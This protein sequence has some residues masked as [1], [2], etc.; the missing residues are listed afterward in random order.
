MAEPID[1]NVPVVEDST[2]HA[3][4]TRTGKFGKSADCWLVPGE[5]LYLSQSAIYDLERDAD[6]MAKGHG[7]KTYSQWQ[8]RPT[9]QKGFIAEEDIVGWYHEIETH[10]KMAGVK[11]QYVANREAYEQKCYPGTDAID[12]TKTDDRTSN[13]RNAFDIDR[14]RSSIALSMCQGER[15]L[16]GS[17][18]KHRSYVS[19]RIESPDGRDLV[20]ICMTFDQ[21]ASFLVSSSATPCTIDRFW[22]INEGCVR[23]KEVVHPPESI[24]NRMK[25]RLEDRLADAEARLDAVIATLDEAIDAGKAMSKTKLAEIRKELG[26]FK[27]HNSSNRDF[28]VEQ[29]REE[30]SSIVERAAAT[31]AW[32]QKIEPRDLLAHPGVQ[33]LL[34]TS[35][36]SVKVIS[37]ESRPVSGDQ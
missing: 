12:P 21:F 37:D 19:I 9:Y 13:N 5:G 35:P 28:T 3:T 29:A 25:Q 23:L 24:Q 10:R 15:Y 26:I 34:S 11:D 14:S 31:I 30:V 6:K 32:D 2:L 16:N 20:D 4:P 17:A 1:D 33:Q 18:V 27:G 22:S 8:N 36:A 7:G